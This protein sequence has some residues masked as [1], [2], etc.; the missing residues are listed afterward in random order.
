MAEGGQ[1]T[2]VAFL[3][4]KGADL[5]SEDADGRTPLSRAV[6]FEQVA[7]VSFLLEKGAAPD[8]QDKHGQTALSRA[9][10]AGYVEITRLM[11]SK[12]GMGEESRT[13]KVKEYHNR[14]MCSWINFK[15]SD[16]QTPLSWAAGNGHEAIVK[17]L[18]A[19]GRVDVNSM[20]GRGQTPLSW[21][22][23]NGH[24]G[25][26]EQLLNLS[27]INVN[28]NTYGRTP[29]SRAIANRH[30]SIVKL[31]MEHGAEGG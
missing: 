31:L 16:D 4:E 18:L 8:T 28:L 6:E 29:L 14:F 2:I 5:K 23:E 9:A 24:E 12:T 13:I 10:K 25:I 11:L 15:D 22:A 17:P 30:D 21:A 27:K 26:V 3:L 20:D 1:E 7:M 19:T